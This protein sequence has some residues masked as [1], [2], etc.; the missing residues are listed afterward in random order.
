MGTAGSAAGA[1]G[2]SRP[3]A[4][5]AHA[6]TWETSAS[7][8]WRDPRAVH[9]S[10][11]AAPRGA[12]EIGADGSVSVSVSGAA[13]SARE[14][15]D[16]RLSQRSSAGARKIRSAVADLLSSASLS[17][18]LPRR[19]LNRFFTLAL[20]VELRIEQLD[21]V[22]RGL[23]V[24]NDGY[25]DV[26]AFASRYLPSKPMCAPPILISSTSMPARLSPRSHTLS[27]RRL[28]GLLQKHDVSQAVQ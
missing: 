6:T 7:E 9:V 12:V 26:P 22:I 16:E 2:Q 19:E 20:S 10:R 27:Y 3:G 5:P 8:H 17:G 4:L 25:A 13:V 15:L 14:L 23:D 18:A 28:N 21:A 1:R 11:D 24:D